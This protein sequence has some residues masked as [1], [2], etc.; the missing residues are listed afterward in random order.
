MVSTQTFGPFPGDAFDQQAQRA[1]AE[2]MR[3]LKV[4]AEIRE[5]AAGGD[6]EDAVLL[7]YTTIDAAM[8][9]GDEPTVRTVLRGLL[10]MP[11]TVMLGGLSISMPWADGLRED[12]AALVEAVRKA[13]PDR[14]AD[15][16][17]GLE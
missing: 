2:A 3:V 4:C 14:A 8:H 15:L 9:A 7:I 13:D 16:L 6:I 12:R 1:L 5:R 17:R 11:I 10:G